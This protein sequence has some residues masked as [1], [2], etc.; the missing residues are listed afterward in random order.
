M[1]ISVIIH[2][3]DDFCHFQYYCMKYAVLGDHNAPVPE[4]EVR[5][6][7]DQ[8]LPLCY[9]SVPLHFHQDLSESSPTVRKN[10]QSCFFIHP[11]VCLSPGG[12]VFRSCV[13]PAGIRVEHLRGRHHPSVNNSLVHCHRYVEFVCVCVQNLVHK[14]IWRFLYKGTCFHK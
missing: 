2:W 11:P 9:I 5:R 13:Y 10:T 1:L 7:Q 8:P 3:Y 12:Y 4:E 6:D 14:A